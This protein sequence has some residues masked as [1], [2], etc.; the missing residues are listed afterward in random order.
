[1]GLWISKGNEGRET[2]ELKGSVGWLFAVL[3]V[4]VN[5]LLFPVTLSS[6]SSLLS[7][8]TITD[9]Q[10]P[11]N[12]FSH[13]QRSHNLMGN[14]PS[15]QGEQHDPNAPV[16]AVTFTNQYQNKQHRHQP[17]HQQSQ[18]A[19][20]LTHQRHSSSPHA[21][22]VHS[23]PPGDSIHP[24]N[25]PIASHPVDAAPRPRFPSVRDPYL[26]DSPAGSSP[27]EIESVYDR[28]DHPQHSSTGKPALPGGGPRRRA[29]S[30]ISGQPY[31]QY[32]DAYNEQAL[33]ASAAHQDKLDHQRLQQT[34]DGRASYRNSARVSRAFE[35]LDPLKSLDGTNEG[36]NSDTLSAPDIASHVAT[37]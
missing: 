17:Q 12:F 1:M 2:R 19:G 26:T 10:P 36:M 35:T 37:S 4:P 9:L 34:G 7:L 16:E 15:N 30:L 3:K 31:G 28:R 25:I 21:F 32:M 6:L 24:S 11:F 27:L 5:F 23:S 20:Y 18:N 8:F 22:P 14:T 13:Q 33:I 29:S